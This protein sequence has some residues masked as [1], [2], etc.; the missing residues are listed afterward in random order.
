MSAIAVRHR[1]PRGDL[2]GRRLE[3]RA[4]LSTIRLSKRFRAVL[5]TIRLSKRVRAV[6]STIRLSKRVRGVRAAH[7]RL[8]LT[9]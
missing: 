8:G 9:H 1:Q 3:I 5:S 2:D 7:R 4:V 6:L